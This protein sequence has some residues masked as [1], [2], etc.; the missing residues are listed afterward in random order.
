MYGAHC[1]AFFLVTGHWPTA[2]LHGCDFRLCCNAENPEHVHDGTI[3]L[4]N[5][6]MHERGRAVVWGK[7]PL[8][9]AQR[10]EIA[11]RWTAGGLR[12]ADLSLEYGVSIG[13]ISRILQVAGVA[14]GKQRG[15]DGRFT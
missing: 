8:T 1:V 3:A 13:R 12:E 6:E 9:A 10:A 2:A 4:N 5:Q 15:P 11:E 14:P 7:T